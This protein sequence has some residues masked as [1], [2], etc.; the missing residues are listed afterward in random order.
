MKLA[1]IPPADLR[2]L[3]TILPRL[4]AEEAEIRP[5]LIERRADFFASD[6]LPAS[7]CHLY[8]YPFPEHV[9]RVTVAFDASDVIKECA[10]AARPVLAASAYIKSL[11]EDDSELSP[12]EKADIRPS[13]GLVF[14]LLTSLL[15]SL[16]CVMAYG[17]YL[18][19]LVAQ[20]RQGTPKG[21]SALLKAVRIDP[22][23]LGTPSINAR[24][25]RAVLERDKKFLDA[26][27][28]AIN[29][30][31]SK[32]HQANADKIRFVL[33]VLH[34]SKVERLNDDELHDLFVQQLALYSAPS[35]ADAGDAAKGI[36]AIAGRME[37]AKA[38]T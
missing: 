38:S 14:G 21:D 12:E 23:A 15:K 26:I 36:R 33:Q 16:Q 6:C 32:Q 2:F 13:L 4:V 35:K 18:N 27:K 10:A 3:L 11:D 34:E 17:V 30:P 1:R 7:W 20:V 8:E 29:A 31:L 9:A 19:D 25:S 5:L 24:M 22:T 28:R 37:K